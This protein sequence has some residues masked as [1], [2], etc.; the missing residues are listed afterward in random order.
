MSSAIV[1]EF[2]LSKMEDIHKQRFMD[3]AENLCVVPDMEYA[4]KFLGKLYDNF[5]KAKA[6]RKT[7]TCILIQC[8]I[9]ESLAI[10]I[11]IPMV[12]AGNYFARK[13]AEAALRDEVIHLNF[14]EVWLK[15]N[16]A[17]AKAELEVANSQNL[18]L[19]WAMLNQVEEDIKT[20]G[21][22]KNTIGE[23]FMSHYGE[24]LSNIG[25]NTCELM[26]MSCEGLTVI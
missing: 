12:S 7:V 8:L 19:V 18:P 25:F 22:D 14:G 17:M 16:F 11:Y 15:E 26:K 23:E 21:I 10:A 24:A 5:Q 2:P 4:Q 20:I 1:G 6:E 13:A 9:I 3:S